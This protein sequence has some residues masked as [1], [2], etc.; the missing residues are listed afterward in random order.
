MPYPT[1]GSTRGI[2]PMRRAS[3]AE[4]RVHRPKPKVAARRAN[5]TGVGLLSMLSSSETLSNSVSTRR[6][7]I[8]VSGIRS[9]TEPSCAFVIGNSIVGDSAACAASAAAF[10]CPCSA[11]ATAASGASDALLPGIPLPDAPLPPPNAAS[12]AA[13]SDEPAAWGTPVFES[14]LCRLAPASLRASSSAL[15]IFARV[16]ESGCREKPL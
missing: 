1:Y 3:R 6:A 13:M 14:S 7:R 8:G 9:T 11:S 16:S 4:I 15:G 10:D 2:H 5:C 12:G